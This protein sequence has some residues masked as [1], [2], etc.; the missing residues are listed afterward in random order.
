MLSRL[1][2]RLGLLFLVCLVGMTA[3]PNAQG[4]SE[5]SSGLKP[6]VRDGKYGYVDKAGTLVIA[7]Q[8]YNARDFSEG[9]APVLMRT[10]G[11]EYIRWGYI[12]ETG[13]VVIKPQFVAAWGFSEGLAAVQLPGIPAEGGY[14]DRSGQLVIKVQPDWNWMSPSGFS[15]GLARVCVGHKYPDNKYGYIDKTGRF[16]IKPQFDFAYD[17]SD[18][19]ATV[20]VGTAKGSIDLTGKFVPDPSNSPMHKLT[21]GLMNTAFGWTEAPKHLVD[22]PTSGDMMGI[23]D[24]FGPFKYVLCLSDGIVAAGMRELFGPI[25]VLTFPIPWPNRYY[26]SPY[27]MNRPMSWD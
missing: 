24:S 14:I 12:D 17:F 16:V 1:G 26:A 20:F 13:K 25:E 3:L 21:R 4:N 9:L 6:V 5:E 11:G 2:Y 19:Q 22:C 8:F 7:P 10:D 27:D 18:G 23:M 15:D